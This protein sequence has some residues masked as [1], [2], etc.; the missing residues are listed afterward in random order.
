MMRSTAGVLALAALLAWLN[1]PAGAQGEK[2]ELRDTM[3]KIGDGSSGLFTKLGRELRDEEPAWD[4]A[5]KMTREIIRLGGTLS[6]ATPPKGDKASWDKFV[7]GFTA[8]VAALDQAV[9]S[10]DRTA[11]LAAW[12]KMES[13]TCMTCHKEHRKE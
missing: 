10:R 13:Q 12:K 6:K 3:K 9:G 2:S 4:N 11:A 5:R 7:K 8:D 1:G